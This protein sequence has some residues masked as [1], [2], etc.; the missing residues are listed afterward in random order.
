MKSWRVYLS[1]A[2][3]NLKSTLQYR[4]WKLSMLTVATNSIVDF[5]AIVILFARFGSIGVWE[6]Y[7]ILL[8]YGIATAA[9][10]LAE[11]FSRGYDVF[12]HF[13][14]TGFFDRM[15]VRPRSTFLQVMGN[16]FEFQRFGRVVV[17]IGCV[18][19]SIIKLG[20]GLD[21]TRLIALLGA[22]VGG[23]MVY[24]G[25]FMILAALSFWTLQP[26]DISYLFTNASLGYA[27]IPLPL[28][29]KAIQTTLT[30]FLP[31]GLCYYYPAVYISGISE[32]SPWVAF[33][34]LPGGAL[35]FLVSLAIWEFGVRHYHSSGN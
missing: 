14:N 23:W 34:A 22:I 17:G 33:M 24:T 2:R 1:Y 10:G 7:H 26:L 28:L 18:S 25:V 4:A 16:R 35:F 30:L 15:L 6:T 29:G 13:V 31:I 11:W 3:I 9:F 21:S 12:P 8:I 19:N 27:Q 20:C 5:M 32:Y